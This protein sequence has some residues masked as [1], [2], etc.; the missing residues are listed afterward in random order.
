MKLTGK[1]KRNKTLKKHIDFKKK[2]TIISKENNH[3]EEQEGEREK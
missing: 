1:H 3:P 2:D